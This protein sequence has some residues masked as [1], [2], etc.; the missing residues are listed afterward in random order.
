MAKKKYYDAGKVR[1]EK[2]W[3]VFDKSGVSSI[4]TPYIYAKTEK[5][6]KREAREKYGKEFGFVEY[7]GETKIYSIPNTRGN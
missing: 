7:R 2:Q 3:Q 4:Y 5:D 1:T 6:A